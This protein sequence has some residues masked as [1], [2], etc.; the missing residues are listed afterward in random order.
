MKKK[1]VYKIL[2]ALW[3]ILIFIFSA[4]IADD[5]SAVSNKVGLLFNTLF[6]L[7]LTQSSPLWG[8]VSFIVRKAAHISE[9]AVLAALWRM[10]AEEAEWKNNWIAPFLLTVFY[11]CTDEFHQTF[12]KG[13]SGE[14]RD[15]CVDSA[16]ALV[17]LILIHIIL[18]VFKKVKKRKRK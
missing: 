4:Q 7:G 18:T 13:R 15:V 6:N 8:T 5:S 3:M 14:L 11:A 16:G 12:V 1:T 10:Y 2:L 9:Y 17:G